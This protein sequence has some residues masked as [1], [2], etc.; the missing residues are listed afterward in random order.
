MK[1]YIASILTLL[2]LV[3][4][5]KEEAVPK[6]DDLLSKQ[7]MAD[8][9]YDITLINSMKGVDKKNLEASFF[10]YDTY[11]YKKHNVDSAQ[12]AESNNYYAAYPLKYD[13]IY[14][15]VNTRFLKERRDVEAE[16]EKEKKR[17]DSLQKAKKEEQERLN[18]RKD[19]VQKKKLKA[20]KKS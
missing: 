1:T 14:E 10:H 19:T 7:Q 20:V 15:L 9:L 18:K 2:L 8:I 13:K 17:R 6:P 5:C 4:S 16:L 12:F 11:L 3:V